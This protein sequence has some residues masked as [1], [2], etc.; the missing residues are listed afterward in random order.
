MIFLRIIFWFF[1]KLP[2]A[3]IFGVIGLFLTILWVTKDIG[4]GF[5]QSAVKIIA[6]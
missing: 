6:P 3:L 5:L 1:I 2:I 4:I